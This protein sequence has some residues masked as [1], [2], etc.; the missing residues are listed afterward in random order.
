MK[1]IVI[2]NCSACD[3]I[4]RLVNALLE[5]EFELISERIEDYHFH[6]LYFKLRGNS[7]KLSKISLEGFKVVDNKYICECHW[8]TIELV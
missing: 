6:Q 1:K 8:S 5:N 7:D 3:P 4:N 2:N